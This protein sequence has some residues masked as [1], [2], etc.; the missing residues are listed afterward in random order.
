PRRCRS[1]GRAPGSAIRAS[2]WPCRWS[3]PRPGRRPPWCGIAARRYGGARAS[4]AAA[5]LRGAGRGEAGGSWLPASRV[6]R[7]AR[8]A[9]PGELHHVS[10]DLSNLFV[11]QFPLELGHGVPA[12]P[13]LPLDRLRRPVRPPLAVD[14]VGIGKPA[15]GDGLT[16]AVLVV[17]RGAFFVEDP[18]TGGDLTVS[19]VRHRKRPVATGG[20]GDEDDDA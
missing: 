19:R 1:P 3:G 17:A 16:V 2:T 15:G 13:D 5:R 12:A 8:A 20:A 9:A 7:R 11:G 4:R 14:Q 6:L 10:H 18:S